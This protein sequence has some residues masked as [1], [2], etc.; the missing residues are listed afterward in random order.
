MCGVTLMKLIREKCCCFT[1]HRL[2]PRSLVPELQNRLRE[3]ILRLAGEGVNIFL[4]GGALGFDTLAAQE[5]LALRQDMPDLR[6]VLVLPCLGQ[7]SRWTPEDAEVYHD[8][9]KQA[10]EAIYTD[11]VYNRGCMFRR[12]RYLVDHSSRCVCYLTDRE[13]GGTAYTV[14]YARRNGLPV[15][16]LYRGEGEQTAL[17]PGNEE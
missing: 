5:V 4:A 2:I 9:I 3:E 10:D 16:N 1:G 7:E 15:V 11:D 12:N 8:L 17:F 13:K 14:R 6:L